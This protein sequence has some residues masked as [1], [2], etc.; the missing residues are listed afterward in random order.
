MAWATSWSTTCRISASS[1]IA[2][3]RDETAICFRDGVYEPRVRRIRPETRTGGSSS[4]GWHPARVARIRRS[5]CDAAGFS[6]LG[7]SRLNVSCRAGSSRGPGARTTGA[8]AG[9]DPMTRLIDLRTEYE[10]SLVSTVR[11]VIRKNVPQPRVSRF[12]EPTA[13]AIEVVIRKRGISG[14]SAY[15]T[16]AV[17][18]VLFPTHAEGPTATQEDSTI[19]PALILPAPAALRCQNVQLHYESAGR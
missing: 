4:S 3:R 2:S 1:P 13:D 19:Q 18:P 17:L 6:T 14:L 15:S 8:A 10:I 11:N 7:C 16:N 9:G 5:T 12:P